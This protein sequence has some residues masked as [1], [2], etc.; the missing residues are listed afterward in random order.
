MTLIDII[1]I[2]Y[3]IYE[4][5]RLIFRLRVYGKFIEEKGVANK[6][7]APVKFVLLALIILAYRKF[8]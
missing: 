6:I 5:W 1:L 3:V 8:G 7:F 4:F 2:A